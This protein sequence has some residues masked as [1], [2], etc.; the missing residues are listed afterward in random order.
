MI[1]SSL[2]Q[3]IFLILDFV[4]Y[5]LLA[6]VIMSWLLN[7]GVL[8]SNQPVVMQIWN[9]LNRILEPLYRPIRSFLPNFGGVDLAPLILILI[10]AVI[11]IILRNN[12][13]TY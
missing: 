9:S 7:F 1:L 2:I 13:I 12:F 8:N 3:I 5:I 10:I 11:K 4:W 6:Q